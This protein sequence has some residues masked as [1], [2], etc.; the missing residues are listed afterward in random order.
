MGHRNEVEVMDAMELFL[1]LLISSVAAIAVL[2]APIVTACAMGA[3][4]LYRIWHVE[5][6]RD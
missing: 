2:A 1:F 3:I 5:R 6:H 4:T